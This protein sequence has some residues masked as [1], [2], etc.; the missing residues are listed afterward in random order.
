MELS[1]IINKL[2]HLE[3]MG[4]TDKTLKMVIYLNYMLIT[5]TLAILL[6]VVFFRLRT[7]VVMRRREVFNKEWQ[8]VLEQCM[9]ELPERLPIIR[10]R[11]LMNFLLLWNGMQENLTGEVRD[12]L[13]FVARWLKIDGKIKKRL[14]KRGNLSER[15]LGINTVGHMRSMALWE[16]LEDIVQENER[17]MVVMIAAKALARINDKRAAFV[18]IP[19]IAINKEWPLPAVAAIVKEM[20]PESVGEALGD[21]IVRV[22]EVVVPRLVRFLRFATAEVALAIVLDL[23]DKYESPDVIAACLN[24][25][26]DV[27]YGQYVELVRSYADHDS[28]VVRLQVVCALGKIGTTDDVPLLTKLLADREWW[29]RYRAARSLLALPFLDKVQLETILAGQTDKYARGALQQAMTEQAI[30]EKEVTV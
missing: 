2:I 13:N 6:V 19:M 3:V 12:N 25:I 9:Y 20:R 22:P 15:L 4:I 24:L 8:P 11:H 28:W 7:I 29:I 5:L 30:I 17:Q 1:S 14:L 10:N 18:I 21:V 27:D 23:L 26:G 16:E